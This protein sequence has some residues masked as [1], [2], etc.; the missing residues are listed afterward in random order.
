MHAAVG[1]VPRIGPN[2]SSFPCGSI[3]RN[4]G[5]QGVIP[6]IGPIDKRKLRIDL[7]AR[8]ADCRSGMT[9]GAAVQVHSRSEAIPDDLFNLNELCQ[10]SPKKV[11]IGPREARQSP[12][13]SGTSI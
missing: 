13:R 7:G 9:A 11:V 12:T 5:R 4:E 8:T 6:V 3:P 10:A 2:E 1:D